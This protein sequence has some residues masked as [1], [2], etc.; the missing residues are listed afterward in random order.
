MID[1]LLTAA[2]I[3]MASQSPVLDAPIPVC[4]QEDGRIDGQDCVWTDPDTGGLWLI[5]SRNYR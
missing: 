3:A 1:T 2:L 4:E 5:D